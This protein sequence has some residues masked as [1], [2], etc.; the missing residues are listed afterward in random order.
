ME[1]IDVIAGEVTVLDRADVDTDQIMPKQFL[2]R[3]ERSGFVYGPR[4]DGAE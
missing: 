4:W 3:V 1:P 2:K